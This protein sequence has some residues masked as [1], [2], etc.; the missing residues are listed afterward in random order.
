MR[1]VQ[2]IRTDRSLFFITAIIPVINAI[3]ETMTIIAPNIPIVVSET[4]FNIPPKIH[5]KMADNMH[6]ILKPT[7]HLPRGD[8]GKKLIFTFSPPLKID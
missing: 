1:I 8:F 3:I 6:K 7:V 2:K 4:T 5:I